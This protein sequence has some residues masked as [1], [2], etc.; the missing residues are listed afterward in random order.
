MKIKET[1][2]CAICNE[3]FRALITTHRLTCSTKCSVLYSKSD[4]ARA[5][6]KVARD[7]PEQRAKRKIYLNKPECKARQK[8][9][10]KVQNL[11]RKLEK[12]GILP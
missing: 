4:E 1:R 5:R 6:A 3:T 9:R 11:K 10:R 7:R 8:A 2:K 12:E